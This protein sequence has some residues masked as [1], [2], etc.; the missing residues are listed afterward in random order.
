MAKQ[1][2][3]A[4]RVSVARR[5]TRSVDLLRDTQDPTS[6]DGYVLTGSARHALE[7][8]ARGLDNSSTQRALRIVG[9][10]GSGKSSFALFLANLLGGPV[11]KAVADSHA[12][13]ED[14]ISIGRSFG[15]QRHHVMVLSGSRTSLTH[16]LL[17]SLRE[18]A[19]D[20]SMDV[21]N[22]RLA[23][24]APD[25]SPGQRVTAVLSALEETSAILSADHGRRLLLI[26]DEMGRYVEHAALDKSED[27]SIFQRLA[28]RAGGMSAPA[29][30]VLIMMH[31]RFGDYIAGLGDA[32]EAEWTR[33]AERYDEIIFGDGLEQAMHLLASALLA[34]EGHSKN[35]LATSR[36][37]YAEA[38]ER[39]ILAFRK[40]D[41]L[42]LGE[43]LYPFHPAAA[44]CLHHLV[45]RFAQN[46]RSLFG[47]L[48]S[49]E[50]HGF[51]RF[52][53]DTG[54]GPKNLLRLP[55]L[56]DY[57]AAQDWRNFGS[58]DRAQR[59][60]R[61][62]DTIGSIKGSDADLGV[63]KT[64]AVLSV[65]EP[66]AGLSSLVDDIAWCLGRE[67]AAIEASL[68]NLVEDGFVYH[69]PQSRD[70]SLWSR[71]SVNLSS[72]Y[73]EASIKVPSVE[74][75]DLQNLPFA[76]RPLLAQAHY[77]RTG[78]MRA[79]SPVILDER[80]AKLETPEGLDGAVG[81][82]LRYPGQAR[83]AVLSKAQGLSKDA[84]TAALVMV[85]DVEPLLLEK[86]TEHARWSHILETCDELRVDDVARS[87]V[88]ARMADAAAA[89]NGTI[90]LEAMTG[91]EAWFHDGRAI[92]IVDRTQL[93][94]HLSQLCDNIFPDGPL[95]RNELINRRKISTAIASARTRLVQRMISHHDVE[96]LGL[97]GAPPERTIHLA[98]FANS[99]IHKDQGDG[100]FAFGPP[101]SDAASHWFAA[102]EVC[103]QAVLGPE[104]RSLQ[105]LLDEL[106]SP[107]I[108]LREAPAFLLVV[109][110]LIHSNDHVAV[111]ERG[112]FLPDVTDAHLLR[113]SK[114][115]GNF[116]LQSIGETR[117]QER[118]LAALA[119]NLKHMLGGR[120]IAA[121]VKPLTEAIFS[122]FGSL[123][124]V[125]KTTTAISSRAQD[126]RTALMKTHDPIEL[127]FKKLPAAFG[128]DT[129][130]LSSDPAK[131]GVLLAEALQ[132]IDDHA[133]HQR[134]LAKA[135]LCDAFGMDDII[136]L[137]DQIAMDFEPWRTRLTEFELRQFVDR[138]LSPQH[139]LD[140]WLDGIAGLIAG[141]RIENWQ[142]T[143]L[144]IFSFKARE[145][146]DRLLRWLFL[147]RRS[148]GMESSSVSMHLVQTD[149]SEVSRVVNAKDAD[150][151][152]VREL[153]SK[154]DTAANPEAALMVV[155]KT[156][157][158]KA[159]LKEK[160]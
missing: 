100:T 13:G 89:M 38:A 94:R 96:M 49:S 65:L 148:R 44:V 1:T 28:E 42:A 21:V 46:D 69:R 57:M 78:T 39:Q 27:A 3:I 33:S 47:F 130:K 8:L 67:T 155:L 157:L 74:R 107:P 156:M 37:A 112:T 106:G 40:S 95:L 125:A 10:Y 158:E 60:T 34:R 149:G 144:D 124:E 30:S 91:A 16:D 11:D 26:I 29:L 150:E 54:Y 12:P 20:F 147:A 75:F 82:V 63:F 41:A 140:R 22:K 142:D 86:V 23:K 73:E 53:H 24:I 160:T 115:P 87:E 9:P 36:K 118:V 102:W 145:F 92:Q 98:M 6:L 19:Q 48:Q 90:G 134:I 117:G 133:Q 72:L 123:D 31:H 93:S 88:A 127:L 32:A 45:R 70:Y 114:K 2:K 104:P 151:T 108:G 85:Q 5:Y 56:F 84:G 159:E 64:V 51:Q 43:K 97:E 50:L 137:R 25:A 103:R 77:H 58:A 68:R 136:S 101:D 132:E 62:L 109:A 61:A 143:S 7:R 153:Q 120:P 129:D 110:F 17:K 135:A 71:T 121:E 80:A 154:L 119:K 4:D 126:V 59:W 139:D 152:L 146:H 105:A 55:N 14:P 128:M 113:A 116:T 83:K 141:R 76:V 15:F 131:Y 35:V 111:M 99:G 81:I 79:F 66:I 52:I 138:A 122:W 18:V